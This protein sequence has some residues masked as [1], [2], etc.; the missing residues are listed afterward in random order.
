[1]VSLHN[2]RIATKIV[3]NPVSKNKLECDKGKYAMS[4][5]GLHT[6]THTHKH[7]RKETKLSL[8]IEDIIILYIIQKISTYKLSE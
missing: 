1:M 4:I 6:G 8:V 5:S 3:R 7:I 2:N